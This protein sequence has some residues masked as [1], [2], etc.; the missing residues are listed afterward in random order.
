SN[1]LPLVVSWKYLSL[2]TILR[3]SVVRITAPASDLLKLPLLKF[4]LRLPNPH[5][6]L[7]SLLAGTSNDS[8]T[9]NMMAHTD[10]PKS[11]AVLRSKTSLSQLIQKS[12]WYLSYHSC[13]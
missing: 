13:L 5:A 12:V 4:F 6:T 3:C 9:S 1:T 2:R 7:V 10:K 11:L 8:G